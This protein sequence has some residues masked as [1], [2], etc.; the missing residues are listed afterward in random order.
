[1]VEGSLTGTAARWKILCEI[2]LGKE[3]YSFL[4]KRTKKLSFALRPRSVG[5]AG[6]SNGW[7]V[8]VLFVLGKRILPVPP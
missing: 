7:T 3:G 5:G 8:L 1:M 2:F 4:E 6:V